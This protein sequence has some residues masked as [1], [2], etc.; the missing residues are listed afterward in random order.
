[1]PSQTTFGKHTGRRRR[2]GRHVGGLLGGAVLFAA[3]AATPFVATIYMT[4]S[5]GH[6]WPDYVA[7]WAVYVAGV[8]VLVCGANR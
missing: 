8:I 4:A 6:G 7:V 3:I 5:G 2:A 1:M